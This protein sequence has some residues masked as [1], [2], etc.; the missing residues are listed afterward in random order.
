MLGIGDAR[1]RA[2][3][4]FRVRWPFGVRAGGLGIARPYGIDL[5]AKLTDGGR[6][7]D[8]AVE[9]V[10]DLRKKLEGYRRRCARQAGWTR[11]FVPTGLVPLD[12]VLP[13]GGLPCGAIVDICSAGMGAG[14]MALAVRIAGRCGSGAFEQRAT[15]AVEQ[16]AGCIVIVDGRG[17][18]YPPAAPRHGIALDRLLVVRPSCEKEAFWATEQSLRCPAVVAVIAP[19]SRLDERNSR[20]L[21]LAAKSSGCVGLVLRPSHRREKSFAAVQMLVEGVGVGTDPRSPRPVG[22][23]RLPSHAHLCRITLLKVRE[24]M[25]VES[26]LVD[27][28]HETGAVSSLSVPV[29]R[30]LAKRA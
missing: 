25:P 30:P 21:Q 20:R 3:R 5:M 29:N 1:R 22:R 12:A 23:S 15:G 11:R 10:A 4:A 16:R 18:F 14:E 7:D 28:H 19:L 8:V 24:G 2:R 9:V 27:L 6:L 13:H 26:F 17:D